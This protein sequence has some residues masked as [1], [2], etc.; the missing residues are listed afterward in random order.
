MQPSRH[1]SWHARQI[2]RAPLGPGA[3]GSSAEAVGF[4]AAAVLTAVRVAF[5]SSWAV[6]RAGYVRASQSSPSSTQ[7]SC[8]VASSWVA[9][10]DAQEKHATGD[11]PE[12]P[13]AQLRSHLTH[14]RCWV[15]AEY[16]EN[17][18]AKSQ[19]STQT[20]EVVLI[21]SKHAMHS[22]AD[23]PVQPPL[24]RGLHR[25]HCFPASRYLERWVGRRGRLVLSLLSIKST[26]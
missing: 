1:S 23:E 22:E 18:R 14:S 12:Q 3:V 25:R 21:A 11:G 5:S 4:G 15:S 20:P 16:R 7:T 19:S 8:P 17:S 10:S 9:S 13:P 26:Y 24:Q 2:D 6:L